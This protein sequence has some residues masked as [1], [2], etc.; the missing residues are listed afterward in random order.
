MQKSPFTEKYSKL[1]WFLFSNSRFTIKAKIGVCTLPTLTTP[2]PPFLWFKSVYNLVAFSPTIK[3]ASLLAKPL[4]LK[5]LKLLL[6]CIEDIAF[7]MALGVISLM[8]HLKM[9]LFVFAYSKISSI[10]ICPSSS[11]SPQW[12][13]SVTSF[14]LINPI[15]VL[16]WDCALGIGILLKG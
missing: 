5:P 12:I 9:G 6:L 16:S 10:R 15:M 14:L 11:A 13:I 7:C 1:L 8:R 2:C 4:S 3:S